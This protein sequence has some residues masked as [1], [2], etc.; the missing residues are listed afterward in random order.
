MATSG[1]LNVRLVLMEAERLTVPARL[2]N[3]FQS[4]MSVDLH[5]QGG[6]RV[7]NSV[8]LDRG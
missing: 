4:F 5:A 6:L 3:V 8:V 1:L 7:K 2:S